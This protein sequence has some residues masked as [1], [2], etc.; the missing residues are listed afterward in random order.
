M[1]KKFPKPSINFQ[2]FSDGSHQ[3]QFAPAFSTRP[4]PPQHFVEL[5][6]IL[7]QITSDAKH[8][9]H[10][11][12]YQSEHSC[13]RLQTFDARFK[14][15]KQSFGIS[16]ALFASESFSILFRRFDG[17]VVAIAHQMPDPPSASLIALAALR[18]K[19]A[20]WLPLTILQTSQTAPS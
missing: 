10:G 19:V 13:P 9:K 4:D 16:K 15:S 2:Q 8:H 17:A 7:E 20:L 12:G 1:F 14:K 6:A 18:D 3:A 11:D 5:L